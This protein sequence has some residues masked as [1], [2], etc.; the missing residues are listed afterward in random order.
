[1]SADDMITYLARETAL[2]RDVPRPELDESCQ[3]A[4]AALRRMAELLKEDDTLSS[5]VRD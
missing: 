3:R 2:I 4:E 1:M 5:P